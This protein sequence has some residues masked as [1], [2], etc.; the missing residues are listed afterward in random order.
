[1]PWGL[2]DQ[3]GPTRK[4]VCERGRQESRDA[5]GL[6]SLAPAGPRWGGEEACLTVATV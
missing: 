6:G 2:R 3:T 5:G 1:M 4:E